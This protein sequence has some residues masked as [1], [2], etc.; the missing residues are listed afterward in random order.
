M[1]VASVKQI[2]N[3]YSCK[4]SFKVRFRRDFVQRGTLES[5][6]LEII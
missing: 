1:A 4:I 3:A 5:V 6:R 2:Y